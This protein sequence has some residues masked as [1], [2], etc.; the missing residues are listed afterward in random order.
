MQVSAQA[1]LPTAVSRP[2]RGTAVDVLAPL[3]TQTSAQ[4]TAT[5]SSKL[6]AGG[7]ANIDGQLNQ[8]AS[9][10][11]QTLAFITQAQASLGQ[12]KQ[13]I[14][15][16]LA[17]QGS[18]GTALQ[19]SLQQFDELWQTRAAASGGG[20]D[21]QLR[22]AGADG[23]RQAFAIRGLD[24]QGAQARESLNFSVRGRQSAP[25]VLEPGLAS[26]TVARRL[27]GVLA[28]LGVRAAAGDDGSLR[29]S[30]SESDWPAV[31][32]SLMVKGNGKRF[33]SGSYNRVRTDAESAAAN[34][35][36]WSVSDPEAMRK[37]LQGAVQLAGRLDMAA[38]EATAQLRDLAGAGDAAVSTDAGARVADFAA[39]FKSMA[40]DD[41]SFATLSQ[42]APATAGMD[43]SR[44]QALLAIRA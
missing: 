5:A 35:Q 38:R 7:L 9:A 11:Q 30:T 42:I 32:D 37:T 19:S 6:A 44:V 36:D 16:T 23:A 8:Q 13:G 31:R 1:A 4:T 34:P 2:A 10:L 24:G 20:L 33:P 41:A 25:V 21:S 15:D 26:T 28:P 29:F 22:I 39:R 18:A 27:D 12:L 17:S 43:R 3:G 40:T 14:G